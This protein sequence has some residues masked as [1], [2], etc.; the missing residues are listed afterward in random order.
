MFKFRSMLIRSLPAIVGLLILIFLASQLSSSVYYSQLVKYGNPICRV[1]RH[2]FESETCEACGG[3]VVQKGVFFSSAVAMENPY[4]EEYQVKF[5]DYYDSFNAFEA[6]FNNCLMLS[7]FA[8][9]VI[10][11]EVVFYIFMF[12]RV[13]HSSSEPKKLSAKGGL[14]R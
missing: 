12:L 4:S 14:K 7:V 1:D 5:A 2:V 3:D 6:D 10:L 13:R 8:L 9:G 11:T